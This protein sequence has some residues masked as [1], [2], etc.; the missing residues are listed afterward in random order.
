MKGDCLMPKMPLT[1]R[2]LFLLKFLQEYSEHKGYMPT[3]REIADAL[4]VVSN[5]TVFHLLK[6]LEDKGHITR[7]RENGGCSH[8]G[9][10]LVPN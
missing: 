9:I 2:Q 6:A 5:N 3:Y 7:F 1:P 10:E 8:R 4:D